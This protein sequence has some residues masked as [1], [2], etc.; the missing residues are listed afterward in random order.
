[1]TATRRVHADHHGRHQHQA[2][3]PQG[4]PAPEEVRCYP[5]RAPWPPAPRALHPLSSPSTPPAPRSGAPGA[6]PVEAVDGVKPIERLRRVFSYARPYRGRLAIALVCLFIASGLGLVHPYFFGEL[7]GAAF[8]SGGASDS[9][10]AYAR[11]ATNSLR[12]GRRLP[13]PGRLRLLP[14]LLHDLARR[15]GGHRPARRP[16]S[17]PGDDAAELLPHHPHRRAAVA[18]RRRRHPPAEHG[19]PGPQHLPAQHHHADRRRGDPVLH[20]LAADRRDAGRRPGADDRRELLEPHHPRD[21]PP[22]P[23]RAGARVRGAA[24]GPLRDRDGAGVHPRA[25]SR[26]T[27]TA[28]RSSAPSPCSSAARWRAAGSPP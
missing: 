26:S 24:G 18:P 27:A 17:P 22:G 28:P 14:P 1:M 19:R 6:K 12:A 2:D 5:A 4:H 11:S 21:Q 16:V 3:R 23:G 15:A 10:A 7:A 13:G 9:E 20:E 25:T 8:T